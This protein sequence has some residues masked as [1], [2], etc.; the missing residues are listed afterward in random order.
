LTPLDKF[1]DVQ[2][3]AQM[4]RVSADFWDHW[5]PDPKVGWSQSL[6]A[7]FAILSGWAGKQGAGSWPDADMLPLGLI[8][9]RPGL[10]DG[11]QTAFTRDEQRTLMTLWSVFRSPLMMA[12]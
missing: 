4:W 8:G 7:Q 6:K 2:Q 5:G 12:P 10:G 1:D 9:P 11:R 3:Y